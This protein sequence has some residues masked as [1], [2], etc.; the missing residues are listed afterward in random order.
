MDN[1]PA[2]TM[3]SNLGRFRKKTRSHIRV[4]LAIAFWV[5]AIGLT[6]LIRVRFGGNTPE[7]SLVSEAILLAVI[8]FYSYLASNG[9]WSLFFDVGYIYLFPMWMAAKYGWK[10]T[11]LA[12]VPVG[13]HLMQ[14]A[15]QASNPVTNSQ[16]KKEEPDK[17]NPAPRRA[18]WVRP[19]QQF[20]LL[21]CGVILLSHTNWLTAIGTTV[22]FLA[23][24]RAVISMNGFL[25]G[26]MQGLARAQNRLAE[27][28]NK[29]VDQV[30]KQDPASKEFQSSVISIRMYQSLLRW[31]SNRDGIENCVQGA[32]LLLIVPYYVYLSILSGFVYYGIA[33]QLA[34]AWSAKE[35]LLDSMFMPLAWTDLPH[36][37]LIRTLAGLQ[38]C[39]LVFI[40]YEAIL[41]RI[42]NRADRIA[43]V[44]E[45]LSR[46]LANPD[47]QSKILVISRPTPAAT[48]QTNLT[49]NS[50]SQVENT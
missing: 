22:V 42:S 12:A 36:S 47:L 48:A 46:K 2:G 40:G 5:H 4:V 30:M 33:K 41:H 13:R 9:W 15:N 49:P 44:A 27:L 10:V 35:A 18:S 38:V 8:F 1:S 34:F 7:A 16:P 23:A 45:E 6:H 32:T 11:K 31:L 24:V 19:F 29:T 25:N 20:A 21:W 37:L 3:M 39:V 14:L 43:N 26:S 17:N 50:L 28:L